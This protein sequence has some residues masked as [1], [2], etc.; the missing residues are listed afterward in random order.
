MLGIYILI[1]IISI[2]GMIMGI[3][4]LVISVSA[5]SRLW[6]TP[7]SFLKTL[8]VINMILSDFV[9]AYNVYLFIKYTIIL[10]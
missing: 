1:I 2:L 8:A 10:L 7:P 6:N 5:M 3:R 4:S 9:I